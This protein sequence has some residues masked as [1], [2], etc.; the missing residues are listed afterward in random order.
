MGAE[1]RKETVIFG[2]PKLPARAA[3]ILTPLIV[4]FFMTCIVSAV[5]TINSNG[6]TS[7]FTEMWLSAWGASWLIAFPALLLILPLVRRI[8]FALVKFP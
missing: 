1:D 3:G 4:S 7:D 8:V 2:I 6:W 5:S